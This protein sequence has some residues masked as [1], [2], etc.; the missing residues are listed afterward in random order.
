MVAVSHLTQHH[1][2]HA[3][4]RVT[5]MSLFTWGTVRK[6][7]SS[8]GIDITSTAVRLI[9]LS[10]VDNRLCVEAYSVCSL[11]SG[12]VDG[13]TIMKAGEVGT[14]IQSAIHSSDIRLNRVIAAVPSSSIISK[15]IS[16]P[17]GLTDDQMET[18]I[19][20]DADQHI[21]YPIEEVALDF[22]VLGQ[23]P[24]RQD[25][26][27][28]LLVA[29]R[30]ESIDQCLDVLKLAG[31]APKVVDIEIY[32][33]ERAYEL[34]RPT[35]CLDLAATSA[36]INIG[37]FTTTISVLNRGMNVYADVQVFG[38]KQPTDEIVSRYGVDLTE[39]ELLLRQSRL[40][41]HEEDLHTTFAN[42]VAQHVDRSLQF[43]YS[44][45]AFHSVDHIFLGGDGALLSRLAPIVESRLSVPTSVANPF[46]NMSISPSVNAVALN[47]DAPGMMV[48]VGL[49]LRGLTDG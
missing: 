8:V 26:V 12:A 23:T 31:I 17:S 10:E 13:R 28:V 9:E 38:G 1:A 15:V 22:E 25:R 42:A 49:A 44:S 32:A 34:V 29:C 46:V 33:L 18:L 41:E 45:S 7:V 2:V 43:F 21:P 40:K 11:P 48:A 35:A 24:G 14:A 20:L 4:F 30:R 39:A 6:K 37:A 27:D 3:G 36:L 5:T 16:M 47:T 19:A